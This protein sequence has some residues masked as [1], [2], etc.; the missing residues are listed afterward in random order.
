MK[1]SQNLTLP[2]KRISTVEVSDIMAEFG[3]EYCRN[4][5]VSYSEL[6]IMKS[7]IQCRTME[8]GGH[9]SQCDQCDYIDIS[10]N[11]CR[12]RHC[13]KCQSLKKAQWLEA[14]T[15]ELLP[16]KYFHAVFTIP[17]E[18]NPLLLMNK[19]LLLDAL[20]TTVKE[21]LNTFSK[22]PKYQL[23]GQLGMTSVLHTW[24]QK[25]NLHYH[26]HCLIPAGVFS[27]KDSKWIP[28][29]QNFLFPVKA[30]SKVFKGK[31]VSCLRRLYRQGK[32]EF[33]K[34][35]EYLKEESAF[36]GL[37]SHIIEKNWVVYAKRP[38][39]S[40][41]FVL[42]YL[43]RYTH[44]V[45]ISNNRIQDID[46]K[47]VKFRFKNRKAGY[48]SEICE[49]EGTEFIRRF[50]KHDLPGGFQRIRH[51]GFLGNARKTECL[52]KI[53]EY[54][55]EA[56]VKK[57]E[58]KTTIQLMLELTGIDLT[59]CPKCKSGKLMKVDE[60][61]G[62]YQTFKLCSEWKLKQRRAYSR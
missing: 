59:C 12:N 8:L 30:L 29:Q 4:R 25:M 54:L 13:P 21:T 46:G 41:K 44:R 19:R 32:L 1:K 37:L 26:L 14:R 38:F 9:S 17:H 58:K 51:F 33:R 49:I 42:D 3:G 31:Y 47:V 10:Y 39:K 55:G 7:I 27:S 35:T 57:R 18:L 22:N 40:P 5:K 45:A 56:P 61:D 2:H 11:S 23:N 6:K 28:C 20:F 60:F 24:D 52:A 48:Q 34:S 36:S 43:G 53:R 15:A 62:L 50:L 16:V